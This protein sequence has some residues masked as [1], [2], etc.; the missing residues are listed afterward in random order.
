MPKKF[1][2]ILVLTNG[3]QVRIYGEFPDHEW[4]QLMLFHA[5]AEALRVNPLVQEAQGKVQDILV[6]VPSGKAKTSIQLPRVPLNDLAMCLRPFILQKESTEFGRIRGILTRQITHEQMQAWLGR[7][8]KEFEGSGLRK[9]FDVVHGD[10]NVVSHA[11]LMDWLHCKVFH[12][13]A[14]VEARIDATLSV[15]DPDIMRYCLAGLLL[16]KVAC[17]SYLW[18]LIGD[19]QSG[20][21]FTIPTEPIL[22][23]Y[24]EWR[25]D[26]APEV[27]S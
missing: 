5:R 21:P 19:L 22:E 25:P 26:P 6:A 14:E 4:Q 17:I 3:S 15:V 10:I 2:N 20:T 13:D 18:T 9:G 7:L 24:Q 23:H 12:V 16:M 8:K 27:N 11:F 1:T